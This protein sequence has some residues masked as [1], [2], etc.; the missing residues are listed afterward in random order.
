[1]VL[2]PQESQYNPIVSVHCGIIATVLDSVMGCAVHAKLP[3]G[4]AYTTLKSR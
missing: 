2:K 4:R 3:V 1:M